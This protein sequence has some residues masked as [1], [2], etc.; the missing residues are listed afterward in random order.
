MP[1]QKTLEC[2]LHVGGDL[3]TCPFLPP[4]PHPPAEL[5][6]LAPTL[7]CPPTGN[8]PALL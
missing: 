3:A 2:K 7:E 4:R 5:T 1:F 8:R 6:I